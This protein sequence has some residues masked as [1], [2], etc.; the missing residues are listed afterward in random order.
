MKHFSKSALAIFAVVVLDLMGTAASAQPPPTPKLSENP[1][2]ERCLFLGLRR[3]DP[4]LSAIVTHVEEA[5]FILDTAGVTEAVAQCRAALAAF[6][7]EPKVIIAHYNAVEAMMML[8]FGIKEFPAS[9]EAAV[10]IALKQARAPSGVLSNLAWFYLGSAYTYGIGTAA[11]TAEA[12]RWY[13]RA[14]DAGNE[15][16]KRELAR[17]EAGAQPK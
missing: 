15:A 12:V 13:R 6:P 17:L 8:L 1:H 2:V 11:D 9:D 4:K 14:A 3:Q 7:A 10:A 16:A 5:A